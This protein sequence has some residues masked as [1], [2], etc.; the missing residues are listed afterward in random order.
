MI[1]R[2]PFRMTPKKKNVKRI[3]DIALAMF[4]R[5]IAHNK[6]KLG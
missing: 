4:D 3:L 6:A 1:T 5:Y 2:I